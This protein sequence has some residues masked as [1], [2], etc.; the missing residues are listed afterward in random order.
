MK[1]KSLKTLTLIMAIGLAVCIVVSLLTCITREPVITEQ[2]FP[3]SV[4]YR[5]NG[6]TLTHEGVYRSRFVSVTKPLARYYEGTYLVLSSE[7][8]PAA[9]TIAEQDNLELCILSHFSNKYLMGD[10]RGEPESTFLYDPYLVVMDQDGMEYD[11]HDTL[12][13]FDAELISWEH[14]EPVENSFR[15]AGF[16]YLYDISMFAMLAV[17]FLVILACMIFVKRDKRIPYK[18]LDKI[19]VFLNFV[20]ALVGIPFATVIILFVQIVVSTDDLG[21]QMYLCMPA[22]SAFTVAASLALRRRGFTKAGFFI[23]LIGVA[24]FFLLMLV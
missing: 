17:G 22:F 23:Q 11:D 5:L 4:T 3:Y 13:K 8:H 12:G 16:S 15:F 19:S 1:N 7:Y 21:Y 9:Y 10:T 18:V 20:V 14:P 2:D 24:P 6:E